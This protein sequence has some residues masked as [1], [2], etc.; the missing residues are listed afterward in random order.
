M[1]QNISY[2]SLNTSKIAYF[3][4]TLD[5]LFALRLSNSTSIHQFYDLTT[6]QL[7]IRALIIAL[8]TNLESG[9]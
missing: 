5:L 4:G 1:V 3:Q 7:D 9:P 6:I 2:N 8:R